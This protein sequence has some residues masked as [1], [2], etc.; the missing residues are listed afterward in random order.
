[1]SELNIEIKIQGPPGKVIMTLYDDYGIVM[2]PNAAKE[3]ADDAHRPYWAPEWK[4]SGG[5]FGRR[6]YTEEQ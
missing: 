3:L 1:M 5:D 2:S 6:V 4:C